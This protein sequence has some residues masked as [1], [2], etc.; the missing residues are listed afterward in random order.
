MMNENIFKRNE[1]ETV[2]LEALRQSQVDCY[3]IFF[4]KL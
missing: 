4:R 2:K 3:M 1:L